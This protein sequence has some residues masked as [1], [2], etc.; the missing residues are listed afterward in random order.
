MALL[1]CDADSCSE[2]ELHEPLS[3]DLSQRERV[4]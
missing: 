1:N 2:R 4:F 3:I